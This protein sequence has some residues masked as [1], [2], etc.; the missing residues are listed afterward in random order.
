MIS[1]KEY[2]DY[3]IPKL[4]E[5]FPQFIEH[6]VIQPNDVVNIEYLSKNK[7]LELWIT[8]QDK[9]ITIGLSGKEQLNDWHTHMSLFGANTPDEELREAAILLTA[10]I[11]DEKVITYS[12]VSGY[13]LG[14][15]EDI[16]K[17]RQPGEVIRSYYWSEL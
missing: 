7:K 11:T 12:S 16:E 14:R 5:Y 6:C 17:Y 3:T 8:T 13:F 10:I 9:E 1:Q 2:T 4:L 15:R